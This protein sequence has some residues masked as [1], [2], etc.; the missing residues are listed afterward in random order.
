LPRSASTGNLKDMQ[1][2]MAAEDVAQT[3]RQISQQILAAGELMSGAP[4][5]LVG[6]RRRGEIL[7]QRIAA[8]IYAQT[9]RNPDV[10]ALDITMYRDDVVG[11]RS[12]IIPMGTEMNFRIDDRAVLLLDDVLH[13]GRSVRAALDALVDF[14]RPRFI[15]LAVLVDRG[16]REYPI[17]ADFVGRRL[18]IPDESRV[19]VSL[20]PIDSDDAVVV[21]SIAPTTAGDR[22]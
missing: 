18:E 5:A 1:T 15:R 6:I 3:V 14:G 2:V 4:L 7:A 9:G 19:R 11:N 13:T 10:G 22:L 20:K 16:G 12:I 21:N 8:A 17:S